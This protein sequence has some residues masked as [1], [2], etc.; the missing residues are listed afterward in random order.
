MLPAPVCSGM[1]RVLVDIMAVLRCLVPTYCL[2]NMMDFDFV[3]FLSFVSVI[4]DRLLC[5]S[6]Q[7]ETALGQYIAHTDVNDNKYRVFSGN[8]WPCR[9]Y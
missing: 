4:T 6:R 9:L 7:A 5:L 1:N 3:L 8:K 2:F